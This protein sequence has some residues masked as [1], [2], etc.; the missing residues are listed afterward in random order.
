MIFGKF[1]ERSA[2]AQARQM[3][4]RP[5]EIRPAVNDVRKSGPTPAVVSEV[6]PE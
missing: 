4:T 6:K 3:E 2:A 5:P 1:D